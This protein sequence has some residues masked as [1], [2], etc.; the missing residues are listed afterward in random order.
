[1]KIEDIEK[2]AF[3]TYREAKKEYNTARTSKAKKIRNE[4]NQKYAAFLR[5]LDAQEFEAKES[6]RRCQTF[7]ADARG[8]L[9]AV[10]KMAREQRK[11][12][13]AEKRQRIRTELSEDS[14]VRNLKKVMDNEWEIACMKE[15]PQHGAR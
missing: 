14:T 2:D 15:E 12:V 8:R 7:L 11:I 13:E 1:M 5:D 6:V 3:E 4:F 9:S 10:K